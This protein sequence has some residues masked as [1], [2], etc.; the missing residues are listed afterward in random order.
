MPKQQAWFAASVLAVATAILFACSSQVT[1][2][3]ANPLFEEQSE[4]PPDECFDGMGCATAWLHEGASA[5]GVGGYGCDARLPKCVTRGAGQWSQQELDRFIEALSKLPA[6]E[7]NWVL[8]RMASG[9]IALW[10]AHFYTLYNGVWVEIVM[11]QHRPADYH[12]Y[13]V[14]LHIQSDFLKHSPLAKVVGLMC[15]ESVHALRD[16]GNE[17]HETQAFRD[18]VA[19][20]MARSSL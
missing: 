7:R 20:C 6:T 13:D 18:A 17:A 9:Q 10:D 1:E 3:Q 19:D 14:P 8:G 16:W 5:D 12:G 11:D 2:P 15:H 4:P